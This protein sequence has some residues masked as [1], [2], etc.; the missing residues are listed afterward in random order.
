M[1]VVKWIES[2][3]H[4]IKHCE[5][6]LMTTFPKKRFTD[7]DYQFTLSEL[8]LVPSAVLIVT[9]LEKWTDLKVHYEKPEVDELRELEEKRRKKEIE[10]QTK[11][12]HEERVALERVRLQIEDDKAA[13]RLRWPR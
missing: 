13:R 12:M 8:N 2:S 1:A 6:G 9:E 5:F 3:H 10:E 11:V 4:H 7:Q